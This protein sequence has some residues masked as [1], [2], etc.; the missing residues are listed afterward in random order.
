MNL[1]ILLD[2]SCGLGVAPESWSPP[3]GVRRF[4]FAGGLGP[5]T[6]LPQLTAMSRGCEA[7]AYKD[8]TVWIDMETHIRSQAGAIYAALSALRD[9][10]VDGRDIFDLSLVRDVAQQVAESGWLLKSSL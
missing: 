6:V 10:E 9:C 8:A 5:S 7:K 4:G 3:S 2:G 1:A